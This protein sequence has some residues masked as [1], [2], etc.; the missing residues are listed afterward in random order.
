V[1]AERIQRFHR[2]SRDK[3]LVSAERIHRLHRTNRDKIE[4]CLHRSFIGYTGLVVRDQ[5]GVHR[6][7]S[8]VTQD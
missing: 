1:S 4:W 8:Y 7:D 3:S 6:E 2:T 5:S